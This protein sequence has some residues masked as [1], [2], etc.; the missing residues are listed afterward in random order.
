MITRQIITR[1]L[2]VFL[3]L[4]AIAILLMLAGSGSAGFVLGLVVVGLAALLLGLL[5]VEDVT[6][7][8]PRRR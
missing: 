7:A 5:V 2:P 4:M 3:L 6:Q 8:G 1:S